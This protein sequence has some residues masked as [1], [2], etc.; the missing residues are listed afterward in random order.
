MQPRPQV[1][2]LERRDLPNATMTFQQCIKESTASHL[3]DLKAVLA[4]TSGQ[5]DKHIALTQV[6]LSLLDNLTFCREE[7]PPPR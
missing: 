4:G 2:E 3:S 1:E 5:P 6:R 7:F